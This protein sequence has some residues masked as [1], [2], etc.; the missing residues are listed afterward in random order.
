[1]DFKIWESLRVV[2]RQISRRHAGKL[3]R[4]LDFSDQYLNPRI[5]RAQ[6]KR[7]DPKA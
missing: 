5:L 1:M 2:A 4:I 7:P 3:S 6:K